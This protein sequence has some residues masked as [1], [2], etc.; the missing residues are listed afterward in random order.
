MAAYVKKSKESCAAAEV[1][2]S[3]ATA[4]PS[5]RT[6]LALECIRTATEARRA[7]KAYE[8]SVAALE[9]TRLAYEE[10]VRGVLR[11]LDTLERKRVFCLKDSLTKFVVFTAAAL[12]S[13]TY[14][15]EQAAKVRRDKRASLRET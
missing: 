7:R 5:I 12:R 10:R 1:A 9:Q 8:A 4:P 11:C 3:A 14:D 13:C 6:S 15:L 2:Q